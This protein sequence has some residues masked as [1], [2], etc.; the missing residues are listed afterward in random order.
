M[1]E[2]GGIF[3]VALHLILPLGWSLT[4]CVFVV[5]FHV[6]VVL[7]YHH[8][9]GPTPGKPARF[10]AFSLFP[11]FLSAYLHVIFVFHSPSLSALDLQML[12]L[13]GGPSLRA[14]HLLLAYRIVSS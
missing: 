8:P 11:F 5:V 10:L 13:T 12:T 1:F 7:F 4:S 3:F 14:L 9:S 6:F 2:C